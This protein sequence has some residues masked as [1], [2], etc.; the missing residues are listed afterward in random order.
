MVS[1]PLVM[2]LMV[3]PGHE[4]CSL[5]LA[6]VAFGELSSVYV[7]CPPIHLH[8]GFFLTLHLTNSPSAFG[9][10][11]LNCIFWE[12]PADQYVWAE[13]PGS[14]ECEAWPQTRGAS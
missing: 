1:L 3:F 7:L 5:N 6:S 10:W 13:G 4:G 11:G 2:L 8:K 9:F 12:D 14:P